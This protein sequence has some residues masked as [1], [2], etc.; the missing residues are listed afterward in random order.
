MNHELK[1]RV[2]RPIHGAP[3][4]VEAQVHELSDAYVVQNLVWHQFPDRV[5]VTAI[6]VL[7]SELRKMQIANIQMQP[8][9]GH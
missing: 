4:E 1:P 8:Q 9:R 2:L 5:M 3:T 6:C 7:A